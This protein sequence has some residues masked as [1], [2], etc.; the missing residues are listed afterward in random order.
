VQS[1]L[2]AKRVIGEPAG[3]DEGQE[4]LMENQKSYFVL[5]GFSDEMGVR[6][7]T[8]ERVSAGRVRVLRMPFTVRTDVAL[9]HKHGIRLQE[10][11]LL[12]RSVLER[13]HENQ[14]QRAFTYTEEDMCQHADRIAA[15]DEEAKHVKAARKHIRAGA[16]IA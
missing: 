7:F 14:E 10:L 4:R 2:V 15:R 12:C 3:L 9:A 16:G 8:F 6:V 1:P 5:N 11:P 13:D